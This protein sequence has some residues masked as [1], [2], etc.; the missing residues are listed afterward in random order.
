MA[1]RVV[2]VSRARGAGGEEVGELVAGRLGFRYVDD[3][4]V[5]L[6]AS[7][8]GI[9]PAE[10]ADEEQR[11]SLVERLLAAMSTSGGVELAGGLPH[12]AAADLSGDEI[13]ALITEAI[14]QTA[15][16]GNVVIVAHAA[17]YAAAP[18]WGALRVLVTASPETR[19]AR[20]G[21]A[22]GLDPTQAARAVKDAD[23]SRRDYLKRFY[24]VSE[25]LP[26]H[27]DLVLNTDSLSVDSAAELVV[28]IASAT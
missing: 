17:S 20:L 5:A 21:A 7:R 11:R 6:A 26:T 24:G 10:V 13:R 1:Y 14:E 25:E 8:G 12:P 27:Y 22:E 16:Q 15:A 3:D 18:D 28:G 23:A 4:I 2:C 19:A 9:S